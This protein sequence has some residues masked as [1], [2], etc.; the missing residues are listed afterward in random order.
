[1]SLILKEAHVSF[2]FERFLPREAAVA[3]PCEVKKVG[4]PPVNITVKAQQATNKLR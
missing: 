3:H 1:M 2:T 4:A